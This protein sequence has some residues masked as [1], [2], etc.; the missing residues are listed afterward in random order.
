MGLRCISDKPD[1]F[2]RVPTPRQ[3][4]EHREDRKKKQSRIEDAVYHILQILDG[5]TR[6]PK[7]E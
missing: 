3:V 6:M 2:D 1:P 5:P 4:L 7:L